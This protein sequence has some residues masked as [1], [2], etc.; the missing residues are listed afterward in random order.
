MH[1][2]NYIIYNISFHVFYFFH[3]NHII[4]YYYKLNKV[5]L[6][7]LKKKKK[8]KKN[9]DK[10]YKF[11]ENLYL[12]SKAYVRVDGK[13]LESFN[14]KKGVPQGCVLSPILFNFIINDIFNKCDNYGISI[15]DRPCCGDLFVDGIVL[16]APTR[17]EIQIRF[18]K[19]FIVFI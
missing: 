6:L 1:F 8:K 3:L 2:Y 13:L 15:G 5:I 9:G 17:S 19:I 7:S 4:Y 16:C 12:S 10:C 18:Y 14:T 11:I